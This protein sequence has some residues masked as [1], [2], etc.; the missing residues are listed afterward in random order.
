MCIYFHYIWLDY[1]KVIQ[2]NKV[3]FKTNLIGQIKIN[4]NIKQYLK[5]TF[6]YCEIISVA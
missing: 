3:G 2:I 5:N 6:Q 4:I 1:N